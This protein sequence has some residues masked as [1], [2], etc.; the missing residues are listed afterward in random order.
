MFT[1]DYRLGDIIY[2]ENYN[3][4]LPLLP[5]HSPRLY[6]LAVKSASTYLL[7]SY[8]LRRRR[9]AH[10]KE[11]QRFSTNIYLTLLSLT[12]LWAFT[13]H[14]IA[15]VRV[16]WYAESENEPEAGEFSYSPVRPF[17]RKWEIGCLMHDEVK[18]RYACGI[19][20]A[21]KRTIANFNV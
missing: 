10:C 8:C 18:T 17:R 7:N 19:V 21:R 13:A 4:A 11:G 5:T 15:L 14:K 12:V 9:K 2:G 1:N 16:D 3:S 20:A 6:C